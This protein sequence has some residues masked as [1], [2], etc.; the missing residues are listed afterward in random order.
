M[1][2]SSTITLDRV[3]KRF[4]A[5]CALDGVVATILPGE[6]IAVIGSSGAGKT[7][8]LR[9]LTG[10]TPVTEGAIRFGAQDLATLRGSALRRHR[11]RVG[12]IYQQFNL[13]KRLPVLTNVLVG[14]L[15]HLTGWRHWA[16]ARV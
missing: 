10:A 16:T 15:P 6:F 2:V 9:C 8:L 12:M 13:M 11:A 5:K 1:P 7:T 3:T 14:R 4:D